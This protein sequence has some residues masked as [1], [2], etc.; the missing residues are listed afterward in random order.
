[1]NKGKF[2][3]IYGMNNLGKTTLATN[4]VR[5]LN[6]FDFNA[7]YI[8][9]PIYDLKPTGPLINDYL[10][11]GNPQNLTPLEAQ[12]LYAQNRRDYEPTLKSRLANGEWIVAEDY[13]GTGICWGITF[14]L[15]KK[16]LEE[17]NKDLLEPDLAL[18][19]DGERFTE[20]IEKNH[21][22]ENSDEL[23]K[24]GRKVHLEIGNWYN[25]I[26]INANQERE[27][28]LRAAVSVLETFFPE[29]K[30]ARDKPDSLFDFDFKS[31][32]QRE[33]F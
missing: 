16:E 19:I 5:Y 21:R 1:M 12:A 8:K 11:N 29:I 24:L 23:W 22:H 3:V 33:L 17:L 14:G 31:G 13:T 7:F 26:K 20:G 28:V 25:W 2:I 30:E 9:Y 15:S 6:A 27:E 4:L 18:L 32:F 10:R